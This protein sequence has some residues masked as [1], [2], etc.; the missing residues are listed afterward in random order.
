MFTT[1]ARV[2]HHACLATCQTARGPNVAKQH[3]SGPLVASQAEVTWGHEGIIH[4][5]DTTL[6]QC[7]Y[8]ADTTPIQHRYRTYTA[9][10]LRQYRV[11]TAP[12]P[13]HKGS[14]TASCVLYVTNGKL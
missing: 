13:H 14:L 10:I 11:D 1:G 8:I 12:I 2:V 9:S 6:K 4:S 3:L 5:A 7:Q